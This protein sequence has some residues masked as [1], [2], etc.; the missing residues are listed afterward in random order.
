MRLAASNTPRFL[1]AT[2]HAFSNAIDRTAGLR[3]EQKSGF[4]GRDG[5][6]GS[7]ADTRESALPGFDERSA[8]GRYQRA[9]DDR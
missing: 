6:K 1:A 8:R 7:P 2:D 3:L 5:E 9:R 4:H